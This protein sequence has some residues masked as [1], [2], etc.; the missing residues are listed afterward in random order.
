MKKAFVLF[1]VVGAVVFLGLSSA[2][3]EVVRGKVAAI[4]LTANK[5]SVTTDK[6]E[7]LALSFDKEDFIVWKGDDEVDAKEVQLGS[8]AEV[9]Y[10][11]DENGAK[12]ASWVDLT[13]VEASEGATTPS[14]EN[15][16]EEATTGTTA[17]PEATTAT[18]EHPGTEPAAKEHPGKE[19][20]ATKEHPGH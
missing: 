8:E 6:G 2:S 7:S 1:L 5:I 19:M 14:P 3:A 9:G 12:I 15:L 4:D 13:P 10:Y 18:K 17:I 20:P 11:A 16:E